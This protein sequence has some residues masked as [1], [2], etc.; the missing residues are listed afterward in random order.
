MDLYRNKH[1][2]YIFQNYHLLPD[3]TVY[4]NLK[5]QL[6]LVGIKDEIEIEKRINICLKAIG[7][8][9]CKRRNVTALSG[10]QQQRVAIARALVKGAKVI[11]ADEPTGNLDSKNSIEVMNILKQLSKTCLVVLVT[12]DKTLANH[13]SDRIIDIKDGQIV[14]DRINE[15]DNSAYLLD[16][17]TIYLD[18][19]KQEVLSDTN[20][21][22]VL[23]TNSNKDIQLKIIV[24][25]NAI[26]MCKLLYFYLDMHFF[27][28]NS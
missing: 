26:Y 28:T 7:M 15:N 19:Y 14:N 11:I 5:I 22:V 4:Q 13:Y 6:E 2:G 24:E 16:T 27:L 17:G 10:G 21:K 20:Q 18:E 25:N 8:E 12:H 1:I 9:K 23:Y 3:L